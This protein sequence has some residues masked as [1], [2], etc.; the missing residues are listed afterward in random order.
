MS[1]IYILKGGNKISGKVQAGGD[2]ISSVHALFMSLLSTG[3]T[4]LKNVSHC[5]DVLK[6]TSWIKENNYADISLINNDLHIQPTG[7]EVDLMGISKIRASICMVSP[8]TI[9]NSQVS[10]GNVGGCNFTDRPIDRHLSLIEACNLRKTIKA[11]SVL[12]CSTALPDELSF[13]CSTKYGP[14]VGVSCHAIM[15]AMKMKNEV[16]LFNIAKEPSVITLLNAIEKYQNRDYI[17]KDRELIISSA[18]EIDNNDI[19]LDIPIDYTV[20][21]TFI[22]A[23]VATGGDVTITDMSE[24]PMW[25]KTKLDEM[26]I[27]YNKVEDG[28]HFECS[29]VNH[30]GEINFEP[31]PGFQSDMGPLLAASLLTI[32]GRSKFIEK[33]YEKRNSHVEGLK[34]M[35]YHV[36]GENSEV[37]VCGSKPNNENLTVY[38]SDIRSGAALIIGALN[39]NAFTVVT[40]ITQI[41]RGYSDFVNKLRNLGVDIYEC[42]IS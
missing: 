32:E 21:F 5:K 11:D 8:L 29:N 18:D 40:N 3:K 31:W 2:K 24:I 19:E 1:N 28:I 4:I 25:L 38:A 33:V 39:R 30:I 9:S 42:E 15:T 17:L 35:G 34:K 41:K 6:I 10:I 22:S 13:D 20:A 36:E 7:I 12:F 23:A 16:R 27:T 14:S 26:N 37:V